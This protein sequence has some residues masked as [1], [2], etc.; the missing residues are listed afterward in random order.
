[1]ELCRKGERSIGQVARDLDLTET[2]VCDWV[3]KAEIDDGRR[4]GLTSSEREELAPLRKE[5]RALRQ[6]RDILK[7]ATA[8]TTGSAC[9]RRSRTSRRPSTKVVWQ[10]R[11]PTPHRVVVCRFG[12]GP[13]SSTT[14]S[15][16]TP[17]SA[18]SRH[19]NMS[20]VRQ[21]RPP[22]PHTVLVCRFVG[23][24]RH[25]SAVR[26]PSPRMAPLFATRRRK[27]GC[28]PSPR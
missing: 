2:A 10:R 27:V 14:T 6:E 5:V 7:R 1:V 11:P 8:F 18:T 13:R 28:R 20:V 21:A 15:S 22:T 17:R 9:T 19:P 25:T 23:G 26:G 4:P 12:A 24:P 16:C 3:R